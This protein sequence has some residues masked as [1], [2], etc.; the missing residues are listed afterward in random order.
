MDYTERPDCGR[1][2][3][4]VTRASLR[5]MIAPGLL[6][7]I[8]PVVDGLVF[9]MLGVGAEAVAAF[10]MVGT[11]VGILMALSLNNS[12]GSWDNAKKYVEMGFD[13]GEGTDTRRGPFVSSGEQIG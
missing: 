13:G 2:V 11:I 9:R 3:G 7:T 1:T 10:L 8:F 12:G 6:A 4:I 5:E